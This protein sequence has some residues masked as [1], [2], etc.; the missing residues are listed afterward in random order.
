MRIRTL[1]GYLLGE[2]QAIQTIAADRKAIWLG[3]LFVLSASFARDYDGEDLLHEPW[4]LLIPLAASLGAS[5]LLF[6][7]AHGIV[8]LKSERFLPFLST[9]RSFLGL[10]WMTAPLA[11]LYA[12]P[13]ERFMT[14][15][16]AMKANLA[17]LAL[18]ALWRVL[19]I[20]RVLCVFLNFR[21]MTA[22]CLVMTFA[23]AV[24]FA[25][26]F[27]LPVPLL[28]VMGGIRLSEGDRVLKGV[29][30]NVVTLGCF[31]LPV[32][33]LLTSYSITSKSQWETSPTVEKIEPSKGWLA[34]L[35]WASVA[36]WAIILPFTQPEQQLRR[37]VEHIFREQR[38]A[39]ALEEMS[40]HAQ[41]DF[42]PHWNPPPRFMNRWPG[43]S[44][45]QFLNILEEIVQNPTADWV[46]KVYVDKLAEFLLYWN[47]WNRKE[48][49]PRI[50]YLLVHL[51]EGPALLEK[52]M[53][54]RAPEDRKEMLQALQPYLQPPDKSRREP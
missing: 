28:D 6:I 52:L 23:D 54:N 4:H 12:I 14:A 20:S 3:F 13:Y 27:F 5:F 18:V 50:G 40:A 46:R 41:H 43:E 31:S 7:F 19:L 44:L 53:E 48:V 16:G 51:P 8:F 26:M 22:L 17:T 9:Y 29:A 24:A 49:L 35:A 39:D 34:Y 45:N 36:I 32:W 47:W 21:P 1:Y 38:I 30:C 15:A 42:P 11:W 33:L 10:F 25:L 37:R 2:R